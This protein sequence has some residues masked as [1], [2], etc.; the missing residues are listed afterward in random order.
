MINLLKGAVG[1]MNG[2]V[3]SYGYIHF[4]LELQFFL[5]SLGFL[6]IFSRKTHFVGYFPNIFSCGSRFAGLSRPWWGEARYLMNHF[7]PLDW[8]RRK[9]TLAA[10]RCF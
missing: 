6:P 8:I 7:N 3:C 2:Y 9:Q 10:P 5:Y 4:E 1:L